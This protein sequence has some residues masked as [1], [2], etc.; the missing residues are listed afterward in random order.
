MSDKLHPTLSEIIQ[1][2]VTQNERE[3]II[4]LML[5]MMYGDKNLK[6]AEDEIIQEYVN[7][8][9]WE[10]PLSLEFYLGKV[11]PKIRAALAD[12]DKLNSLLQDINARIE[13]ETVKIQL[14]KV[15]NDLAASDE[16]FSSPE[17][18]LIKNIYQVFQVTTH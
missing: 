9:Q 12:Q 13:S 8:T 10:S 11:T 2:D 18:E 6:L 1:Q 5:L 14:L 16:E 17:Q 3:A 4:E 15:C 7:N